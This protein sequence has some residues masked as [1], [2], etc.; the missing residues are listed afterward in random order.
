MARV[1]WTEPPLHDLDAIAE[2]MAL[3]Q[4]EAARRYV[5]KVFQH[6]GRLADFP[7]SDA[8]PPEISHL[9]YRQVVL[10]PCRIFY[11]VAEEEVIIVYVMRAARLLRADELTRISHTLV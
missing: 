10:P 8:V 1:T 2:Y 3:D 11:R 9:P 6:V 7:N 5:Q 4:P